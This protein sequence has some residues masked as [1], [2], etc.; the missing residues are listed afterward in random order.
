MDAIFID[1][2]LDIAIGQKSSS[3]YENATGEEIR[4]DM[5]SY[6]NMLEALIFKC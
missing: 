2:P 3:G 4:Q 6:V 1:T 5:E